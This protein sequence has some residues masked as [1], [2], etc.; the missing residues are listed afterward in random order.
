MVFRG[1]YEF[2]ALFTRPV[3]RLPIFVLPGL[4]VVLP[5]GHALVGR[6]SAGHRG[7]YIT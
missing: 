1:L 3:A 7:P 6:T 2:A 5:A 4:L